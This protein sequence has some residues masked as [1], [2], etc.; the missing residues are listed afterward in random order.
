[1]NIILVFVFTCWSQ[2]IHFFKKEKLIKTLSLEQMQ[3]IAGK[4]DIKLEYHLSRTPF[5]NYRGMPVIPL[6]KEIYG[7]ALSDKDHTE[8]IFEATDG[9]LA[10]A[11]RKMLL[12]PGGYIA[13]KDLD[14]ES[15]WTPVGFKQV[16]PGPYILI[17]EQK[18]QTT[19]NGY[20]W[21]W[22]LSK[23]HLVT[24]KSRYPRVYPSKFK[25]NSSVY[26]GY[27]VFKVQCFRCHSID[28]QGGKIGPDLAAPQNILNYRSE[29][30]I[31]QFIRDPS[32]FRYSKMPG[33]THLSRKNMDDLLDYLRS[34]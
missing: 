15:G 27:Q 9:Y 3:K 18:N 7:S 13:Y 23:I 19:A 17:W 5:K 1:M 22:A 26:K 24:L 11:S 8:F 32:V 31:R 16:S 28:R 6:L 29:K 34:R 10:Y 4:K 25:K 2:E 20:P 12:S 21:P 30:F 33:H 14:I